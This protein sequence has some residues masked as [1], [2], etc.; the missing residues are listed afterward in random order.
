MSTVLEVDDSGTVLGFTFD[1]VMKYHGP[2]FP[3]GVAHAVKVL[4]RA[5]PVL[6]PG[7]P[8]QRREISIVTAHRGPG[9]RDTFE[10]V[11]RAVTENRF[12]VDS[13]LERPDRGATLERYVFELTYRG[14]TVRLEI[15]DGFVTDE[16]ISLARKPDRSQAD[17]DR[18]TVLKQE[19]ADRLLAA[20]ANQVYDVV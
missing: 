2:G 20:P 7:A 10:A 15:R 11:T 12:T 19:M 18:L 5:L 14:T 17:E 9:V 1:D 4:E 16:F 3:G 13:A 6:S 8:A